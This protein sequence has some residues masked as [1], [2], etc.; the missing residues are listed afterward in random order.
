MAASGSVAALALL[1]KGV[2]SLVDHF[3]EAADTL[4]TTIN[5]L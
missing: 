1:G 2:M 5:D 4:A 3:K